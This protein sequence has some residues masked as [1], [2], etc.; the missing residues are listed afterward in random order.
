MSTRYA[1][2]PTRRRTRRDDTR[3]AVLV[4]VSF[5]AAIAV[6]FSLFTG[7]FVASYYSDHAA[8]V[9][10]VNGEAISKDAVRD[11]VA[12]NVSRDKRMTELQR[13]PE[14][15]HNCSI[16]VTRK[17]AHISPKTSGFI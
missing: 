7:V 8:A 14:P 17:P 6:A 3:R 13:P 16:R 9:G 2:K 5:V 4:T 12:L 15:G 10:S 1:P 11:R